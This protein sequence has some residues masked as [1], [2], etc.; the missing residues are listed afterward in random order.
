MLHEQ[1]LGVPPNCRTVLPVQDYK[2][3]SY[4]KAWLYYGRELL[5]GAEIIGI[6][7]VLETL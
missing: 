4:K 3:G 7:F 2:H 6:G 1:G 5:W